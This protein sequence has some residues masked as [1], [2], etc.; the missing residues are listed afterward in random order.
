MSASDQRVKVGVRVRPLLTSELDAAAESVI[1]AERGKRIVATVPAKKNAF[2]FDWAFGQNKSHREVY[3][4]MCKPLIKAL[5]EG[6]NATV[7]AYGQTGSGKTFTMGNAAQAT[8]GVIP[9]AVHD[10]FDEKA[11]LESI[12]KEVLVEMS[13][14][15]V[16]MEECYDLFNPERKRIELRE[17]PKGETVPDDLTVKLVQCPQEV[18]SYLAEA[19]LIRATG[20]TAMNAHSSRSHA[21]CTVYLRIS[22]RVAPV[23]SEESSA[24]ISRAIVSKLHLVDLAGSERAKKTGATGDVFAEGVSINKGL[25]ALGNVIVALSNQ[26]KENCNTGANGEV[27][28]D[29]QKKNYIPY[30]DSK[31]TRLLKDSLG[32]NGKTVMLA[33]IS[34]ADVNFE[35]TLNTLR[36]ANRASTIVN[37][38][39]VNIDDSDLV[40]DGGRPLP[41]SVVKELSFLRS[42]SVGLQNQIENLRQLLA[43]TSVS[44]SAYGTLAVVDTKSIEQAQTAMK[45]M[46]QLFASINEMVNAQKV[47]L[48]K[49]LE[50]DLPLEETALRNLCATINNIM[51]MVASMNKSDDDVKEEISEFSVLE[52]EFLPP[53]MKLIEDLDK[54][55]EKLSAAAETHAESE[56]CIQPKRETA[57]GRSFPTL[58][59]SSTNLGSRDNLMDIDGAAT[60]SGSSMYSASDGAIG[61]THLEV[62]GL[63]GIA[64]S[65]TEYMDAYQEAESEAEVREKEIK[66]MQMIRI[67][68]EYKTTIMNLRCEI[69]S[70]QSEK[71]MLAAKEAKEPPGTTDSKIKKDLLEKSKQLEAKLKELRSKE[72]DYARIYQEKERARKEAETLRGELTEA[73]K[74]RVA[75]QKKLKEESEQHLQEKKRLQQLEMQSRKREF[76]AQ[77]AVSKLSKEFFNKEKVINPNRSLDLK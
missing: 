58:S 17:T 10:I 11:R 54:L 50:D 41:A 59:Q 7:F 55:Q 13:F 63:E 32:G 25:L 61:T 30:R 40:M 21:I 38:A 75:I 57:K 20:C 33:C 4:S 22:D 67:A 18:Q 51:S 72:I 60:A 39:Q 23:T 12:G 45:Q 76:Q 53:I 8:D 15:E 70:M 34:P 65:N 64:P 27:K 37:S 29:A 16:Y 5:F 3:D 69:A 31:I 47:L 36:F 14:M 52:S 66:I 24:S 44:Q 74:K 9:Y 46:K 35:E 1:K 2:D 56:L 68:E 73:M 19:T 6:F 62:E 28:G 48:I 26:N 71:Q 42:H 43:D 49:C 77:E